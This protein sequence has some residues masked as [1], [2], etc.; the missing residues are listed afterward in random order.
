MTRQCAR[1]GCSEPAEA[2][3]TYDYAAGSVW[4]DALA[5]E[6]DPHAYDLCRRHADN[7]RVPAGWVLSDRR[8]TMAARLLAG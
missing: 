1:P 4:C 2:T 6:R 8:P 5:P 7:V 3:L